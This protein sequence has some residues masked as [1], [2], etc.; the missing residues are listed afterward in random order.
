M[1]KTRFLAGIL[2]TTMLLTGCS[3]FDKEEPL[4]MYIQVEAPRVQ[5]DGN[6]NLSS[7]LGIKDLWIDQ[8]A[9]FLG[10]IE[11]G[12]TIPVYPGESEKYLLTGGIFNSG[13]SGFR[14]KY[15]F[16]KSVPQTIPFSPLDTVKISPLIT[17]FPRDSA[18]IYPFEETFETG[19][20][21]LVDLNVNS[22]TV[23]L[24][25][26]TSSVFQGSQA[27]KAIFTSIDSIMEVVS[28]Q[29]FSLPGSG[30]NSVW[31]ELTFKSDIPFAAGIYY[32]EAG[33]PNFGPIGGD[34]LFKSND[35]TTVYV[36]LTDPVRA[37][38]GA[39]LRYRV[40]FQANGRG[41]SGTMY[42]DYI[43]LIHFAQ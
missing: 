2:A 25:R 42:I 9:D 18:L 15:P 36:P 43:R 14:T 21:A 11:V 41:E 22:P 10:V 13:L 37:L 7:R 32:E 3:L 39:N 20:N 8:G 33:Q 30:Q 1:M 31:L 6:T 26:S 35:W 16:W 19:G 12:K 40:W 4:P 24:E 34:I 27:G 23:K 28:D 5:L 17:Y 29:T 38:A